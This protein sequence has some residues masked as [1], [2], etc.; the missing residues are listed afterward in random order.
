MNL[1][2]FVEVMNQLTKIR[3]RVE[4]LALN[5][6][7]LIASVFIFLQVPDGQGL[8]AFVGLCLG[9]VILNLLVLAVKAYVLAIEVAPKAMAYLFRV[10][11][12]VHCVFVALFALLVSYF[13]CPK[14]L[15]TSFSELYRLFEVFKLKQ[16]VSYSSTP[17]QLY[18]VSCILI[19]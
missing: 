3:L 5:I 19:E 6:L 9:T 7:I 11:W 14:V 18:P 12:E 1:K 10:K 8:S 4:L 17:Y 16:H 2:L 15:A 13:F